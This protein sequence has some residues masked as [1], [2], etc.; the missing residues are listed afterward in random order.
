MNERDN[1]PNPNAFEESAIER[2]L[3]FGVH[4]GRHDCH[5]NTYCMALSGYYSIIPYAKLYVTGLVGYIYRGH[6]LAPDTYSV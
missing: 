1:P 2:L 6:A 3:F 5:C 4:H